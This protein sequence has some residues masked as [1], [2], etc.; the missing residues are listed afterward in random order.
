MTHTQT[1]SRISHLARRLKTLTDMITL[2]KSIILTK[3]EQAKEPDLKY[4]E[5]TAIS[6][7]I[8]ILVRETLALERKQMTITSEINLLENSLK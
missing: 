6:F 5:V 2:N 8:K 7:D 4:H 3:S 1:R